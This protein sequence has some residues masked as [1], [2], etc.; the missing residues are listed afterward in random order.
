MT[1]SSRPDAM[2]APLMPGGERARP[3]IA[4]EAA[5]F[6]KIARHMYALM[7]RNIASD[8]FQFRDPRCK[9]SLPGCV[10][11]APS[12]PGNT[13]GIDQGLCL[14]LG[15]RRRDHHRRS[16]RRGSRGQRRRGGARRLR[17]LLQDVPGQCRALARPCLF[18][19]GRHAAGVDRAGRRP[20][21]ADPRDPCASSP[22]SMQ[23]HSLSRER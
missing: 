16:R 21:R 10:L 11:A 17:D 19:R 5:S 15:A 13:P 22:G 4:I 3:P 8:G 20:R 12:Y 9:L 1:S 7:L 18:Q 2:A 14:S 23:R 6:D